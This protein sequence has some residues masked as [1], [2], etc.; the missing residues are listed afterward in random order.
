MTC[1][2][3]AAESQR[4][5]PYWVRLKR[6]LKSLMSWY[7]TKWLKSSRTSTLSHWRGR[8]ELNRSSTEENCTGSSNDTPNLADTWAGI[9]ITVWRRD[10]VL[11]FH[12]VGPRGH[13]QVPRLGCRYF[14]SL[15]RVIEPVPRLSHC[16]LLLTTGTLT[17]PFPPFI[18]GV[19]Y[20]DI[21][22]R[23]LFSSSV[24]SWYIDD[25][26]VINP[27]DTSVEN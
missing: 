23:E 2:L 16:L 19:L 15:S 22:T 1:N 8:A 20:T 17:G 6:N 18:S 5:S 13:T 4:Q 21:Q 26:T 7:W 10:W 25:I 24:D 3:Q 27:G 14:Y 11:T 12:D 9:R